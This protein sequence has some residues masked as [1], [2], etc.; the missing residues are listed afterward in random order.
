MANY[1]APSLSSEIVPPVD[2]RRAKQRMHQ[3]ELLETVVKDE[4]MWK[5]LQQELAKSKVVSRPGVQEITRRFLEKHEAEIGAQAVIQSLANKSS[6]PPRR[7]SYEADHSRRS[8]MDYISMT[9]Q[10]MRRALSMGVGLGDKESTQKGNH[11][12]P[13]FN[14]RVHS[15]FSWINASVNSSTVEETISTT[16]VR[17]ILFP[18]TCRNRACDDIFEVIDHAVSEVDAVSY[19]DCTTT[20]SA[21]NNE[22]TLDLATSSDRDTQFEVGYDQSYDDCDDELLVCFPSKPRHQWK[23]AANH[24]AARTA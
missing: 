12:T 20:S 5:E 3:T 4:D 24:A 8:S 19:L 6:K 9:G 16:S 10:N 1:R 18:A 2:P 14:E 11:T 7:S 13:T 23:E 22:A 21:L 17:A 15:S